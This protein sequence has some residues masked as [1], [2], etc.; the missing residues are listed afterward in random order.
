M[1]WL[2][3][4]PNLFV[5]QTTHAVARSERSTKGR[6]GRRCR[7]TGSREPTCTPFW[8]KLPKP[9]RPSD[10]VSRIADRRHHCCSRCHPPRPTDCARPLAGWPTGCERSAEDVA[11]TDLAY[12]LARR[13]AHRP[14]RTAVIASSLD[15]AGRG[16]ARG[17]RRRHSVSGRGRAGRP[18]TGVGVLRAGLAVGGDGRR[19]ARERTGVRRDRRRSGAADRPRV[20]VLGDR[21]DVGAPRRSPVSTGFSRPCSPCRSRWPPR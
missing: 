9:L 4:R 1:S 7:R 12:T 20:R 5:P 6:G 15:R 18:R 3:S 10:I 19:A 21:G 17:R 13:R 8:N 16:V 2:R 14:V 11:L